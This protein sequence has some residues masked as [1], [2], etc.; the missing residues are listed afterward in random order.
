MLYVAICGTVICDDAG[1]GVM[2]T[3]NCEGA[4]G[5]GCVGTYGDANMGDMMMKIL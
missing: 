2:V 5:D 1:T 3:K 4:H